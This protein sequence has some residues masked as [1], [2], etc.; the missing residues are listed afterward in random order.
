MLNIIIPGDLIITFSIAIVLSDVD[1]KAE[2]VG[3]TNCTVAPL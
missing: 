2:A 3:P 1:L